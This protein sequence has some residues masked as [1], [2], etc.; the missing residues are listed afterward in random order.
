MI[1]IRLCLGAFAFFF[2]GQALVTARNQRLLMDAPL[3]E[4][5]SKM[6]LNRLQRQ[7]EPVSLPLGALA[8]GS[9][10]LGRD[11]RLSGCRERLCVY[12]PFRTVRKAKSIGGNR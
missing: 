7:P 3:S 5:M 8:P 12:K 1:D 2:C 11:R 6:M 10:S 4:I 9:V